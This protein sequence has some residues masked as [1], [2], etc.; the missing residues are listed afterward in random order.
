MGEYFSI[1][2]VDGM[3]RMLDQRLLPDEVVYHDYIHCSDIAT[4]IRDMVIRGA[5][6]IGVAAA[7]GL[8]LTAL[9]S[10]AKTTSDLIKQLDTSSV[11]L[12]GSRPTAV[13]LSWAIDR[14]NKV[15]ELN[16]GMGLVQ[17]KDRILVEA[18]NIYAEDVQMD[19]K[20]AQNGQKFIPNQANLIHHCNTGG[21]A[22]AGIGTAL[23]VIRLA[24][25]KGKNVHVF[26]DETRPRLQ[27]ARLTAWELKQLGIPHTLIVDGASGYIMKN[28]KIDACLVGCDRIAANGDIANKIGTYNLALVAAAHG[29]PFYSAGPTTSLDLSITSGDQIPIEERPEEEVTHIQAHPITP[30]EVTVANPAF[31]VTPARYI[32]AIITDRGVAYPPY[33]ESLAGLKKL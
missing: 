22:T 23:G 30:P 19:Y 10:S 31:D 33:T 21:L 20:I 4:A 28:H 25:E 16:A 17:L 27:G 18:Q 32:T 1:R 15:I 11:E 24:H 13:N 12:K 3:V 8:A 29:V 9:S 2:W 26:I 5:P 6:A 14:I 7:F